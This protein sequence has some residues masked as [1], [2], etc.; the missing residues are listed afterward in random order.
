M[1]ESGNGEEA[2]DLRTI[3]V[4]H[5]RI[6]VTDCRGAP[7]RVITTRTYAGRLPVRG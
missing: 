6:F 4:G 2:E 3:G 7:P 1:G 5:L